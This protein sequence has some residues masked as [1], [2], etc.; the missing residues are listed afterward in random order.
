M[1]EP[2]PQPKIRETYQI[3]RREVIGGEQKFFSVVKNGRV[4]PSFSS[5]EVAE[6]EASR[7]MQET[8]KEHRIMACRVYGSPSAVDVPTT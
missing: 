8:G 7:L 5:Q 2:R 1:Y 3:V 6:A 4:I